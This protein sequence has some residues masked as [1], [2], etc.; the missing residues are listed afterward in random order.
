[1]DIIKY[2]FVELWS[3]VREILK[4]FIFGFWRGTKIH[5]EFIVEI[6]NIVKERS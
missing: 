2:F 4:D 5:L 6:F 3:G 1:M